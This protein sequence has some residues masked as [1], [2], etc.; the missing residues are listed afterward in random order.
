M[1]NRK[2]SGITRRAVV[3]GLMVG[4]GQA[5]LAGAPTTSLRPIARSARL[6]ASAAAPVQSLIARAQLGGK[7]GYVVADAS[8]GRV[9]ESLNPLLGLPPAS[10]AKAITAQYALETLGP[11]H[12][13]V[14]RLVAV[15]TMANGRLEGD[16]VLMGG[17]DPAL[18]STGLAEMA[19][20]LKSTGLREVSGRFLV[21]GGNLPHIR[22]IDPDQP[23]YLG[24]N[25]AVSGLNLNFNRVHF[26][27]KRQ[28]D[29]YSVLMDA[30]T[31]RYRPE[32]TLAQ[33]K[34]VD[35]KS[36]VYTYSGIGRTERWTVARTALGK[37]GSRWLPVRQPEL[38]AG[39]VFQIFARAQGIVLRNAELIRQRPRGTVLVDRASPPLKRILQSMLKYSTNL[40]AEV[41]GLDASLA[42]GRSVSSLGQS[43]AEMS[44]WMKQRLG[45][46]KPRFANH[47]G[48]TDKTRIAASDMVTALV[49]IGPDSTLASIMKP[50]RIRDPL[51]N[52]VEDPAFQMVA[53]TGTMNFVSGLAGYMNTG[54]NRNLVFAT[55]TANLPR[56]NAIA[57]A[58]RE[59][60]PGAKSWNG[61]AHRLQWG[62][63]NRWAELYG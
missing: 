29:S 31:E 21:H 12:S 32:V 57:A 23:D 18:D 26:Q 40:T 49:R 13:F 34:I 43:G 61:R 45:A 48:L 22:Q 24:Y 54:E 63:I 36:P 7:I 2:F 37:S 8:T 38:Y 53:K 3:G 20:A 62:L 59:R 35:R 16:L 17:G 27:W 6:T 4:A 28:S 51:G 50:I 10:V 58:D 46:R 55:F 11:A 52:L 19:A 33:M 47:S 42:R 14:T 30:R 60:P 41:S 56:R 39:E 5:A 1:K 25:P 44:G 9:L 15:G